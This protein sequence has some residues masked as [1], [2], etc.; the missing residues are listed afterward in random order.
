[1]A[2]RKGNPFVTKQRKLKHRALI[3]REG[4]W[5]R[6]DSE[7]IEAM[8]KFIAKGA[9]YLMWSGSRGPDNGCTVIGFDTSEKAAEM[10]AWIDANGIADRPLPESVPNQPQLRVGRA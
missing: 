3:R 4:P 7:E 9:D 8:C 1:M 6:R 10:Q 2:T 5:R